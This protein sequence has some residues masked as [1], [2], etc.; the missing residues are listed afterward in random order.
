[1][2]FIQAPAAPSWATYRRFSVRYQS[3]QQ[4]YAQTRT[5]YNSSFINDTDV[6]MSFTLTSLTRDTQYSIEIRAEV[7]NSACRYYYY[8]YGNYSDP[9]S[10]RTNATCK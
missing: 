9:V 2:I 8:T 10:F 3:D 1:M 5:Y 6:E 4:R 7:Q